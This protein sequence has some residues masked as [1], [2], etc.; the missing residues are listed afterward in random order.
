MTSAP[1]PATSVPTQSAVPSGPAG[2]PAP[3]V[4]TSAP[5]EVLS[6][7][8]AENDASSALVAI[9]LTRVPG[10]GGVRVSRLESPARLLVRIPEADRVP[11]ADLELGTRLVTGLRAAVHLAQGG[12]ELHLVFDLA[13]DAVRVESRFEG[14]RLLLRLSNG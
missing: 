4:A 10:G 2:T 9:E 11:E 8:L 13:G 6:V 14:T 7:S 1:T 5:V 12:S 3:P